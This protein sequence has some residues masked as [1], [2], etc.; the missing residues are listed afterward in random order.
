MM[1]KL[2]ALAA[3]SFAVGCASSKPTIAPPQAVRTPDT[4]HVYR[5]DIVLA[6]TAPGKAPTSNSYTL[7]LEEYDNGE[8]VMGSNMVLEPH[9]RMDVGLKIK[10]SLRPSSDG[11]VLHDAIEMSGVDDSAQSAIHKL[12]TMGDAVLRQGQPVLVAS[13]DDPLSHKH[14]QVTAAATLIR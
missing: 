8:I 10:A 6:E 11:I 13:L 1:I 5:L 14:Y 9:M 3:A 12:T 7:N 2:A 4:R